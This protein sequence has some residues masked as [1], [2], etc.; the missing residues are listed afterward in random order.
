MTTEGQKSGLE[1]LRK[2]EAKGVLGKD[3]AVLL[4]LLDLRP[5]PSKKTDR[6]LEDGYV[7]A[8]AGPRTET[9]VDKAVANIKKAVTDWGK[10][11]KLS[12]EE[13]EKLSGLCE[14]FVTSN[15]K[16]FATKIKALPAKTPVTE[17]LE[18]IFTANAGT[19]LSYYVN[20]DEKAAKEQGLKFDLPEGRTLV[21]DLPEKKG[22]LILNCTLGKLYVS[23]GE[24][25]LVE[26]A[27]TRGEITAQFKAKIVENLGAPPAK[28]D[29]VPKKDDTPPKK[30]DTPPKKDDK[31]PKKDDTPAKEVD[32]STIK[33]EPGRVA[34]LVSEYQKNQKKGDPHVVLPETWPQ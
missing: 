26:D 18:K 28:G 14:D 8:F 2:V 6:A 31:P 25:K 24:G 5:I 1:P 11:K 7:R 23:D 32:P 29:V 30:D 4:N 10:A 27:K 3:A 15:W 13:I 12:D 33:D 17:G 20:F 9:P 16:S 19:K 22:K 21:F 34:W